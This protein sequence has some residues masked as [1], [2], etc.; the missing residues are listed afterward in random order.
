[1]TDVTTM[2]PDQAREEAR[3]R[4]ERRDKGLPLT[5]TPDEKTERLQEED[6]RREKE[7]QAECR[8]KY[9]AFGCTVW[10]TSQA[11]ASKVSAGIP[12]LFVTH[13]RKRIAW[14]HEVKTPTGV[15][16]SAQKD[17]EQGVLACGQQYILGGVAACEEQLI[18]IG[19]AFRLSDGSL[20]P[21]H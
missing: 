17:F 19:V 14:W 5:E 6:A 12:D 13:Q 16:S 10:N 4:N 15:Q 1:M 20:E 2:T 8:K 18:R 9:I 3:R 11:R 7:I 21:R